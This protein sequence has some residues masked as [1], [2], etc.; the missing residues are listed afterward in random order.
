M[1]IIGIISKV[2]SLSMRLFG[3]MSSGSILLN[4]SIIGFTIIGTKLFGFALPVGLPIITYIQGLLVAFI[5]AFVFSLIVVIGIK[6]VLN[7][8]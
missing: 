8:D 3:N 2:V 6:S 1:D 4:V 7:E 5:Q